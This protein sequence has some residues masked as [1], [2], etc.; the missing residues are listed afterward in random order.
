MRQGLPEAAAAAGMAP[1]GVKGVVFVQV[2]ER[3]LCDAV[4]LFQL[5]F[6]LR[7]PAGAMGKGSD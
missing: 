4:Q 2:E 5:P 6:N 1:E 3:L 7:V